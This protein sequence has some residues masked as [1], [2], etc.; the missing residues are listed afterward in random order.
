M[1]APVGPGAD[2]V[3]RL[4]T[5]AAVVEQ[6]PIRTLC[7]NLDSA[8]TLVLAVVP[9]EEVAIG[10]GYGPESGQLAVSTANS[11]SSSKSERSS[12][13]STGSSLPASGS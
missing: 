3:R 9:F 6:L 13:L 2:L 11:H 1:Y 12:A 5:R 4:P 7:M 10:F 8:A